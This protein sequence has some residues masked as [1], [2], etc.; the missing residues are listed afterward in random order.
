[1]FD[2][3]PSGVEDTF[4][5]VDGQRFGAEPD[6]RGPIG[7]GAGYREIFTDGDVVVTTIDELLGALADA[8]A[9]QRIYIPG[10]V[11]LDC[12]ERVYIEELCFDVPGGVTI[13]SDRGR[14]GSAGAI[15]RSD[16][17]KTRPLLRCGGEGVRLT[18]LRIVG[19]DPKRRLA[20][21]DRSFKK[22]R[23]HEY[24]YKFPISDGVMTEFGSLQVDNC[25]LAGWSH[26]AI[27]LRGGT[28]HVVRH[29]YIHH[30]QYNGL[31]YGVSHDVA[32]SLIERNSF[33][34]NR[35]SIAGTGRSGSG[36][37]ARHN[38]EL[39]DSLSHCF[40]MH[41]GS[42]RKDGTETAGDSM[43]VTRNTFRAPQ[44]AFVLRGE[45]ESKTL[46]EGNWF[47]GHDSPEQAVRLRSDRG[48]EFGDNTYGHA[49][50]RRIAGRDA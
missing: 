37:V 1:M 3:R 5:T 24:Y 9:G 28:G 36:Y 7:G 12:T 25:E 47:A 2:A 42:D 6:E 29:C 32:R 20:H 50:P 48:V 44:A 27:F 13:A 34:F 23:G 49:N 16:T 10:D 30:C 40:D 43:E 26:A 21:H 38:V 41:G 17:F 31:G 35:H 22:K 45:C 8:A 14:G 4:V 33:D 15:I 11:V 19:P 39:G 18:G 46:L